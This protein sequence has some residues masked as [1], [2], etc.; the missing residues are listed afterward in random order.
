MP[1]IYHLLGLW[2]PISCATRDASLE[3]SGLM[4][5]TPGCCLS[6]VAKVS[7][8]RS[9]STSTGWCVST[10]RSMVPE[11]CP[12]RKAKSST[13]RTRGVGDVGPGFLTRRSSV[14]ALDFH[15]YL[16]GEPGTRLTTENHS[17]GVEQLAQASR[18]PR[19]DC[20]LRHA[21][22]EGVPLAVLI[23]AAKAPHA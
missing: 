1:A 3:R 5:S 2:S 19:E 8:S 18:L 17:D 16:L 6:Q 22:C 13:P 21:F 11:V 10:L 9:S 23:L 20:Q 7:L 12:R 14:S 4:I 15:R